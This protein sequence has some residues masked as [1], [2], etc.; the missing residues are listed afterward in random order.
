MVVIAVA[1]TSLP[2]AVLCLFQVKEMLANPEAFMVAAAPAAAA[3][4]GK[5]AAPAKAEEPEEEEEEDM[6]FSLFD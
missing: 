1:L 6:G 3:D 2:A 4:S 5:A